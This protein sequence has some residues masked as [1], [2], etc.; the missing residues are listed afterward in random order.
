MA[1]IESQLR[2]KIITGVARGLLYL[3]EDSRFKVIHRDLKAS[4]VLLD[5]AMNPK[6]A[7]FGLAKLFD[8]DQ[9]SSTRFT[10]RVAGTYGYMAPGYAMSGYMAPEHIGLL[11]VQ[12][13][14][15]SRPTMA[16]VV[17]MFNATFAT[18]FIP[19][20]W[21]IKRQPHR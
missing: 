7:D 19:R 20:R 21:R 17:V 2:F 10:D 4:N 14:A 5:D 13:K 3:H 1:A 15:E 8:T 18:G 9:P 12:E 6:I 11:C 16:S